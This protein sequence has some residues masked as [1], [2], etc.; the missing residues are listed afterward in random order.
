MRVVQAIGRRTDEL[1]EELVAPSASDVAEQEKAVREIVEDVRARGDAALVEHG[2]RLDWPEMSVDRLRVA[3]PE[4]EAARGEV[5]E[6]F[7]QAVRL[8]AERVRAFHEK[9]LPNDWFD[10]RVP[11]ALLGQKF[12]PIQRVAIHVPGQSVPLPSSMIMGVVPAQVAG[13][14]ELVL[15]TPPRKDGTIHPAILAAAGVLGADTIY[16]I[17]GAQAVAALAYGTETIP[18]VDKIVGPGSIWVTLAKKFVFG[19]VGIEGLYGPSEVVVIADETASPKLLA[20]DLIAQAEH[21]NDS[22]VFLVTTA[23]DLVDTVQKE[24]TLQLSDLPRREIATESLDRYGAIVVAVDLDQ[25]VEIADELA[26]E[27]VQV[28]TRDPFAI[29]SMVRNAGAIFLGHSSPVPLGDYVIGPSHWLPTGRTARFSSGLGTMDFMKR[30]SVVY[31]SPRAVADHGEAVRALAS[32]EGLEGHIR[33]VEA[34][35]GAEG[36]EEGRSS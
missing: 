1:V 7:I 3:M 20:A 32:L 12:T 22:P 28:C 17:G 18:K 8:S 27:H 24:L 31:T 2:R 14:D 36:D 30:S 19:D 9:Q 13:V 21:M 5:G 26:A 6:E 11:G 23:P 16:K 15:V 35:L 4:I 29:L 33:A 34:R 25:A 10:S